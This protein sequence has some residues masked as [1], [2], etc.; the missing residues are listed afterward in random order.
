MSGPA[1]RRVVAAIDQGTTSSR[2][3]LFDRSGRV[4]GSAQREHRQFT[5]RPGWVEH[6]PAEIRDRTGEVV[7]GAL[8]DAGMD[9][10]S[11]VAVGITNQRETTVVWDPATGEALAPAI[12]WQDTRTDRLATALEADIGA[13]RLRDLTGLPAAT[14][15]SG[16]KLQW[17][18]ENREGLRERARTGRAVFGTVETWL[19]WNLTGG[20]VHRTDPTNASRTL[21]MDLRRRQWNDDLL[22]ALGVPR[23]ML[24]EIAP[25][26][27]PEAWGATL[28]DGP[29]GARV[30]IGGVIGDQQAAL[31]GQLCR[32]PGEAKCTYGTGAF[33]LMHTGEEPVPSE[34]GLLTTVAYTDR[35][36]A[37]YAL[38]G[39]V[40]V[41][42]SLVQWLRDQ[43][44]LADSAPG[45][46]RLALEVEDS[47]GAV[48][49]P[50]FSGLFAPHWRSDAR[51]VICGLTRHTDR[52]HLARAAIE[53]AAFQVA[54]V[55]RAM[56]E[57]SG[58]PVSELRVD[59]GMAVSDL[60]LG[61][62]ADLLGVPV[63]RPRQTETTA[64]GA[65]IC[66]GL[67]A[68]FWDSAA[69]LGEALEVEAR[70]EPR[71]PEARRAALSQ[72]WSKAVERSLDWV[73]TG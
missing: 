12:V 22:A 69:E 24:P 44:G 25:S 63:L 21:M 48:I 72:S 37:H 6:D 43:L 53:A 39:S 33:L 13:A 46:E 34:A 35:D 9:G 62:Q 23:R 70:F 30:P 51:G 10:R 5:P 29:F 71:I 36:R 42:G 3:L 65:A 50:A 32:R 31:L 17:L 8:R 66:A 20:A 26:S 40:A 60:L 28:P 18:L 19:V 15:F 59:G 27:D 54:E 56:R 61:F 7:A 73:E 49:V 16:P 14:Y 55:L 58:F 64:L 68:G 1:A 67:A 57:D 47:A 4:A 38:E 45:I 41:A 52:R 11:V 2:C